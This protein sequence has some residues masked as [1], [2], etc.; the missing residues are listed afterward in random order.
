M[1]NQ[2][3]NQINSDQTQNKLRKGVGG[4]PKKLLSDPTLPIFQNFLGLY[5]L[6]SWDDQTTWTH[7]FLKDNDSVTKYFL[8]R[9][10]L[11]EL[12]YP[13]NE[14]RKLKE[15]DSQKFNQKDLITVL[16]QFAKLYGYSV[17]SYTKET[18]PTKTNGLLK[19]KCHQIYRLTT[20][21]KKI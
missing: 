19:K 20:K 11:L 3:E 13:L 18:K 1:E 6:N 16:N 14:V 10:K 21:T 7:Q 2:T 12:S 9:P 17:V 5:G 4:R 8:L 15:S